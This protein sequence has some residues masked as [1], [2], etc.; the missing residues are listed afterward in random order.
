MGKYLSLLLFFNSASVCRMQLASTCGELSVG[1]GK[2]LPHL[3]A[4]QL[5]EGLVRRSPAD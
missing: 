3:S 5:W 2:P 1:E 4:F